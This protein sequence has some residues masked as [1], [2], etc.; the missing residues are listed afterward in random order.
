M[1]ERDPFGKEGVTGV[2]DMPDRD[3]YSIED[4]PKDL[5]DPVFGVAP[6]NALQE[7]EM[8]MKVFDK[9]KTKAWVIGGMIVSGIIFVLVASLGFSWYRANIFKN[10][11]V[12]V[13]LD[14]PDKV[15]G[16]NTERFVFSYDNQN[17]V[18]L[19]NV[20]ILFRF[21]ESFVPEEKDGLKRDGTTSARVEI[22]TVKSHQKASVDIYGYFSGTTQSAMYIRSIL[23]YSPKNISGLFQRET[24]K[25]VTIE[26][27]VI[28]VE[29]T[30]PIESATGD[31][32]EGVVQYTNR[33]TDT[34]FSGK[35][36]IDYPEGF[37]LQ[38]SDFRPSEGD[39]V[40]YL[41]P[42]ESGAV[43]TFKFRGMIEGDRGTQKQFTT[44]IGVIRGD[45]S[46]FAYGKDQKKIQLVG[47]PFSIQVQ[48][49]R[50][51]VRAVSVGT[52]IEF[53]LNYKNNG[54]VGLRDAIVRAVLGGQILD[55]AA[56]KVGQGA[57]DASTHTVIWRASDIPELAFMD[58]GESGSIT[59]SVP[60][61]KS[62]PIETTN[63]TQFTG[64]VTA[65]IDSVDVPDRIG[66]RRIVAQDWAEIPLNSSPS[67][68]VDLREGSTNLNL[69]DVR[70]E[71]GK[72]TELVAYVRLRNTYNDLID[73]QFVLNIPSGV[74]FGGSIPLEQDEPVTYDERAQKLVWEVGR[75]KTATGVLLPDR[76]IAFRI[77][78]TPQEY[79]TGNNNLILLSGIEFHGKDDFTG[80]S[81]SLAP[82]NVGVS[83]IFP[84][85]SGE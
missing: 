68:S 7:E 43:K 39:N 57:Y 61:R 23:Q 40:W 17:G 82:G 32:V 24:Q 55:D 76:V 79:Q 83:Y 84:A 67:L 29:M 60:V 44:T 18:D 72:E 27:S 80:E 19:E 30:L 63:D 5:G 51:D 13:S 41:D 78:I 46:F 11:S 38:G 36:Q 35:L 64:S 16:D 2:R 4:D 31:L 25:S 10:D 42:L 22:G 52:G 71:V 66:T 6:E 65:S 21:P 33:G 81:I 9:K 34:I 56:I 49:N 12:I 73:G 3:R 58:P 54:D 15:S 14:G 26:S 37:V 50:G 62:I 20:V 77:R 47:S 28:N 75:V 74:T 48:M 70:F 8:K 45:N 59:F 69:T 53:T 85:G 1:L